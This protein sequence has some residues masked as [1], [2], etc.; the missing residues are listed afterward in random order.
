MTI[1]NITYLKSKFENSDTPDENDFGDWLDTM[2]YNA[3]SEVP[4]IIEIKGLT[5]VDPN[6][7]QHNLNFEVDISTSASFD[8]LVVQAKTL[9]AQTNWEYWNGISMQPMPP[10]GL[11]PSY[12]NQ[13]VGLVTYTWSGG[14]RGVAYYVR[15]RSGFNSVWGDYRVSKVT[16]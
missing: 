6:T 9:T 5:I 14:Q 16:G 12:Q 3:P 8:A 4:I 15:Y 1:Q 13:D 7:P 11:H 2:F 10:T